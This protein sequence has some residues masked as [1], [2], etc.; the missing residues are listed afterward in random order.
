[1]HWLQAAHSS[2]L[3]FAIKTIRER[4]NDG[5]YMVGLRKGKRAKTFEVECFCLFSQASGVSLLYYL[6]L[7]KKKMR[8]S[9]FQS[10][11]N[12]ERN[13]L[14]TG[15]SREIMREIFALLQIHSC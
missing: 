2:T 5:K 3:D 4:T 8:K 7:K 15:I 6:H 13:L 10:L 11:P 1:M 9:P 14:S 12:V